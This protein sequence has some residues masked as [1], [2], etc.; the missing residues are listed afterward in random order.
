PFRHREADAGDREDLVA[1][2]A[3]ALDGSCG[4]HRTRAMNGFRSHLLTGFIAAIGPVALVVRYG[5]S[6]HRFDSLGSWYT[7]LVAAA[8]SL[9]LA[10]AYAAVRALAASLRGDRS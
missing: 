7:I 1:D 2:L 8:F 5:E 3:R 6:T 4:G 10:V 9:P